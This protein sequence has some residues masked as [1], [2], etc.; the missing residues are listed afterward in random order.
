[1]DASSGATTAGPEARGGAKRSFLAP[2]AGD[3]VLYLPKK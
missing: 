2:F 3:A 1:M